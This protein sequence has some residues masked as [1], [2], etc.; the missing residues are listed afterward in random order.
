MFSK[1]S[2]RFRHAFDPDVY[3]CWKDVQR[4]FGI[5][6]GILYRLIADRKIK[7]ISFREPGKRF[8]CRLIYLPSVKAYLDSL[9]ATQCPDSTPIS[10]KQKAL[11]SAEL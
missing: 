3:G 9:L 11:V 1:L 7:S 4:L 10:L 6:R 5:K 8:G 2:T